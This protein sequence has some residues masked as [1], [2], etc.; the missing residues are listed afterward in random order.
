MKVLFTEFESNDLGSTS[1][2][3]VKFSK[4][5]TILLSKKSIILNYDIAIFHPINGLNVW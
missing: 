4:Y 5:Q 1:V 3:T 2:N